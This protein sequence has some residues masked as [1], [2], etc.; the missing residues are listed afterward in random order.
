MPVNTGGVTDAVDRL[1]NA[2]QLDPVVNAVRNLVRAALGSQRVRDTLHGVWLG[3]PLHPPLTD[4]P[5]G[6]WSAAAILDALPGTGAASATLIT[7][8]CVGYVPT[9]LAGW[10]D[11]AELHPQQQR[12]GLVHAAAGAAAF[13]CY[14]GSLAARA[15]GSSL[16][17]KVW[18]YAGFALMSATGYLGGHLAFRQA[19]GVNHVESVP[20]LFPEGW[21]EIGRLDDLP[22]GELI[23]RAVDGVGLLVVRRGQHVDVLANM[24]SHLAAPLSEGSFMAENGQGC[25]VCPWHGSAFRLSDGAVVHGPATAP[26]PRFET[27]IV[28]GALEVML[29]GAG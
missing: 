19:A 24:C 13:S 2:G 27:R 23:E 7:A 5:I 28:D 25:V 20:H 12:V 18:A 4:V 10:A 8:G 17:G 3:H 1:E 16:R 21:Q 9:I 6:T 14:V 22:D 15:K 11:W 26:M 29:P